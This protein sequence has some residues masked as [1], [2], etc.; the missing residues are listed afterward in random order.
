MLGSRGLQYLV[1][2]S[3]EHLEPD[4]ADATDLRNQTFN[5]EKNGD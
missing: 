1:T 4:S 2:S 5:P 3:R